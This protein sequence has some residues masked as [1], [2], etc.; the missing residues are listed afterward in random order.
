VHRLRLLLLTLIIL[1]AAS[2]TTPY[3]HAS[4]PQV[5][6]VK[7]DGT[8][9]PMSAELVDEALSQA[10]ENSQPVLL[11]LNT[12]GG[13]LDAT[14]KIISSIEQSSVPVI[15]YVQPAGAT[16]WSAGTYILLSTHIAAMAPHTIIG[17]G[18][19]VSFS[20]FGGTQPINDTKI[21]NALTAFLVEKAEMHGRNQTA[22]KGFILENLNMNAEDAK[23]YGVIEVVASSVD[24]LLEEVDGTTITTTQ[25]AFTLHSRGAET[26]H[27][28]P[29][30]RLTILRP[31]SDPMMAFF[32]FIIGLYA[33]IFGLT[34]PG[35]GGEV[36]GAVLFVLGLIGLGV[37][38]V[39][40]GAL[41]LIGLGAALLIAELLT[42]G[43]GIMGG[44]GFS[45]TIIGSFLLF[46]SPWIVSP[47]WL[48]SL[49]TVTL[50]VPIAVGV[51]FIFAAY[52]V[53][54]ARRRRPVIGLMVGDKAEALEEIK[55]DKIGFI[56]YRGEYWKARS[57]S[58]I[59]PKQRVV[60]TGKEGPV[61]VVKPEET[62][63][64]GVSQPTSS[65][66]E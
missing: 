62:S 40:V 64:A 13:N 59:R 55:P 14:F 32:L 52:K 5:V 2:L 53:I 6:V 56:V 57:G 20:P 10:S 36:V 12:P 27:W 26:I 34:S 48:N 54:K 38:G 4:T 33:L 3:A 11:L 39:N 58:K 8:I 18:Q 1:F 66:K 15:G 21:I 41:I 9:T 16:A 46:P 19:P 49:F 37:T 17:S 28:S 51:F 23:R 45:C 44:A 50:A 60:I 65:R 29:S 7:L 61:L 22:A 47:E 35:I 24:E 31:L 43:F 63:E 42:P 30:P 25:G